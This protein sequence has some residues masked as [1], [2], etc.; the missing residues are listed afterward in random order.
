M[1]PAVTEVTAD[2][3][4]LSSSMPVGRLTIETVRGTDSPAFEFDDAWLGRF[5]RLRLSADLQPVPGRQFASGGLFGCLR[6]QIPDRWGRRVLR[7]RKASVTGVISPALPG[8]LECLFAGDD[9]TRLGALRLTADGAPVG[10]GAVSDLPSVETVPRIARA[11]RAF[12]EAD[13]AGKVPP[14]EALELLDGSGAFMG[15]ARPKRCV[16]GSEGE[17]LLAKFPSVTDDG[18]DVS[19]WELWAHRMAA[20]CGIL[21]APSSAVRCD[22]GHVFLMRRFDRTATGGRIHFASAMTLLGLADGDGA[23]TG[24]G[25]GEIA[26]FIAEH[27]PA[28]E[29]NLRELVRRVAFSILIGN[30]DDHFRNH[31]FLLGG[32]DGVPGWTLSPVY[33]INPT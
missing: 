9:F 33:D 6:D 2:L 20:R 32:F 23:A 4:L 28:A 29:E 27:S 31:G 13:A 5:P 18:F 30:A 15:G 10:A 17:I 16:R 12:E 19:L 24:H 7:A 11:V 3:P 22:G 8:D 14:A 21:T 26:D 1:L 25:Y